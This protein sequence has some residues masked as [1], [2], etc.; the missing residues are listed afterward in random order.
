MT[1]IDNQTAALIRV[2]DDL[3]AI[4]LYQYQNNDM[5]PALVHYFEKICSKIETAPNIDTSSFTTHVNMIHGCIGSPTR[6][7]QTNRPERGWV[8]TSSSTP[9]MNDS[10]QSMDPSSRPISCLQHSNTKTQ[11]LCP[12]TPRLNPVVETGCDVPYF[13]L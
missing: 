9:R 3:N 6:I 12:L 10:T 5:D 7:S 11:L 2:R 4:I 13:V 1:S 8:D